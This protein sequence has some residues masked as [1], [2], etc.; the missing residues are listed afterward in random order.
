M[1]RTLFIIVVCLVILAGCSQNQPSEKIVI[2]V[3]APLSGFAS[4]MGEYVARGVTLAYEE[5]S[6]EEQGRFEIRYEDDQCSGSEGLSVAKKL[7]ESEG[8]HYLIGPFC[9]AV[10]IPTLDTY[11]SA[12][13][14]RMITGLGLDSY[15]DH[16]NGQ[17][18][19]LGDTGPLMSSLADYTLAQNQTRIAMIVLDQDYGW[20]NAR[21][22][23][24]RY[25]LGK[26]IVLGKESFLPS[27]SDFRTRLLKLREENPNGLLIIALGRNLIE[28]IRQINELDWNVSLYGIRNMEDPEIVRTLGNL[29]EGIVYPSLTE[30]GTT[31]NPFYTAYLARY[32]EVPESVTANAYD[33]ALV[34]FRT[35]LACGDRPDCVHSA[36]SDKDSIKGVTGT[37]VMTPSGKGIRTPTMRLVHKGQ[38]IRASA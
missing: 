28:I 16:G 14:I 32:H 26:G 6:I 11:D 25:S 30:E 23:E 2:G 37:I 18:V 5:L 8:A 12:G 9:A 21:D 10:I 38:F 19:L 29:S 22:F 20:E 1:A 24:K 17:F 15:E 36:L 35:I 33:S 3:S 34:L 31:A 13:S 27:E 4:T 7:T